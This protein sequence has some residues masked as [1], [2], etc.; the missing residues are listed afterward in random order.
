MEEGFDYEALLEYNT[1]SSI[2]SLCFFINSLQ[3]LK[4]LE[5]LFINESTE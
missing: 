1:I 5:E 4:N 2:S 3:W